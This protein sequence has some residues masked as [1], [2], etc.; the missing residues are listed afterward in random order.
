MS[1]KQHLHDHIFPYVLV[2]FIIIAAYMSYDRFIVRGDYLVSYEGTCDPLKENCFI[3]CNDD[4]CTDTYYYRVME[5]YAPD[6]EA[7]CGKDITDCETANRC[8]PSDTL[9]T[10]KYC[11]QGS[12]RGECETLSGQSN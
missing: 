7:E 8:L 9:C 5:K 12:D 4:A 6:L 10:I 3:G 11:T 2:L 1:L